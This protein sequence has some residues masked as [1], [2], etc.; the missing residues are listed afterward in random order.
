MD[1]ERWSRIQQLYH[2]A[3]ALDDAD[4]VAFLARVGREDQTLRAEIES[5]LTDGAD[6]GPFL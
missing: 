3:A 5:L 2:E 1:A 6:G 4:R